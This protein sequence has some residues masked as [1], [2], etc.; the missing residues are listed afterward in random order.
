MTIIDDLKDA[1][2]N[3]HIIA[4]GVGAG[5]Q[6]QLWEVPGSS[7][8]LSGASSPND[9][10]WQE[11]LLG[12]TTEQFCS[13]TAAIDLASADYMKAFKFGGKNPVG[14]GLTASVAS[15]KSI[16]EII[17]ILFALSLMIKLFFC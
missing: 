4:T 10:T 15:E 16:G 7:A 17:V 1:N 2:V 8:Y 6:K 12:F 14:V 9:Q 11:E 5:I 13:E 3:I